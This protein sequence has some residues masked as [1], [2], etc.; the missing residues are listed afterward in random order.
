MNRLKFGSE[1]LPKR[2]DMVGQSSRHGGCSLLPLLLKQ[3]LTYSLWFREDHPQAHVWT[4]EVVKRLEQD[5]APF[6]GFTLFTETAA[7]AH[8]RRQGMA[9]GLIDALDQTGADF[10]P[11]S[12][13]LLCANEHALAQFFQSPLLFIS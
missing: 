3:A 10:Q 2:P 7:L 5:D 4:R 12:R 11:Q 1:K 9:K 13:Q 6:H 8:Q